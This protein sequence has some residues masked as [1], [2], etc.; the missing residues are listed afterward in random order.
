MAAAIADTVARRFDATVIRAHAERFG[1]ARFGDEMDA[2]VREE[3]GR[4]W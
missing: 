1:R 4:A 2:L 3:S